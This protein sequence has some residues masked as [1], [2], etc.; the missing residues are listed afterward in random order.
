MNKLDIGIIILALVVLLG[1]F[2]LIMSYFTHIENECLAN[3]FSYGAR[4]IR[5]QY[6][7][8]FVGWGYLD[9]PSGVQSPRFTFNST[10]ISIKN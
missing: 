8:N 4:Q 5:Q 9:V 2:Y 7:Y 6:G 10:S 3:P 1:G